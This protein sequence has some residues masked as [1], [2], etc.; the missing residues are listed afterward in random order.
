MATPPPPPPGFGSPVPPPGPHGG[1]AVA[2]PRPTP[3]PP[4]PPR[5]GGGGK[6]GVIVAAIVV[7]VGGFAIFRV[8]GGATATA[9]PDPQVS[10]VASEE[11][12][13]EPTD[14]AT[15]SPGPSPTASPA[16]G[17]TEGGPLPNPSGQ[18]TPDSINV[19]GLIEAQV[20]DWTLVDVAE[21]PEWI[22]LG[23]SSALRTQYKNPQNL[24]VR[25][26]VAAFPSEQDAVA[27]LES[28]ADSLSAEQGSELLEEF[29]VEI[30]GQ[31]AGQGYFFARNGGHVVLYT[32][33]PVM[34]TVAATRRASVI[35]FYR[36]VP[37]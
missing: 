26:I 24:N 11:P 15:P 28:F 31:Q 3:P 12:T 36:N 8:F 21:L 1:S 18:D 4:P 10:E 17:P 29:A 7:V 9:S 27:T 25:H 32:N 2:A 20:G 13:P 34:A 23:A 30:D 33:G 16:P 14:G 22:E 35:D 5:A 37:Y 6:I 19:E